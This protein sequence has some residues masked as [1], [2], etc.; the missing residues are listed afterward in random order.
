M[1]VAA[2]PSASREGC[3]GNSGVERARS[4]AGEGGE[5]AYPGGRCQA[6]TVGGSEGKKRHGRG[7]VSGFSGIE[8]RGAPR[9]GGLSISLLSIT[10]VEI[11]R[12]WRRSNI[13]CCGGR[14]HCG[15]G[16]GSLCGIP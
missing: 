4:R 11:L 9:V 10:G 16:G 2:A 7:S 14:E 13:M 8:G 12:G 5:A 3:G 1:I 15:G 6:K